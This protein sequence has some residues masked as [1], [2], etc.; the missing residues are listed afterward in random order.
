MMQSKKTN[1]E[2]EICGI[3]ALTGNPNVGKSTLF[4]GLTGM[5][6]HTGNWSGKTVS[7]ACGYYKTEDKKYMLIDLP[8][9]YSYSAGTAEE[10][11]TRD[12]LCFEE[13]DAV[14]VVCDA[15]CLERNM[16]LVLQTLEITDR[17]V[18]CIN[19]I[20]EAEK[21]GIETDAL[22]LEKL[23][24]ISVLR[25]EARSGKGLE[26]IPEIAVKKK[27]GETFKVNYGESA[28]KYIGQICG[29]LEKMGISKARRFCA[30]R[31]LCEDK[32]FIDSFEKKYGINPKADEE[33]KRILHKAKSEFCE[34]SFEDVTAEALVKTAERICGRIMRG[35]KSGYTRKERILDRI[36]TGRL[37][38]FCVM[39][40]FLSGIFWLTIEGANFISEIL[41]K[42][43][44]G[45]EAPFGELLRMLDVP[46]WIAKPLTEG[47]WRVLSWVVAVMLPPMAIFFPLFTLL[48]DFGYLPRIAFNLDR[49]F[50]KCNACGKQSLTMCMGFGCNAVGVTGCRIIDSPRERLIAMIT[51]SFVPCNG[52]FPALIAIITMFF[53]GVSKNTLS[54][55]TSAMILTLVIVVG[56][57][58]SFGAS[59]LLSGTLLRGMP[60]SFVLELPSY[61]RPQIWKVIV[62][63]VFDRTLFVLARAVKAAIPAGF[64]I[65]IMANVSIGNE[66]LLGICSQFLEPFGKMIGLDGIILMAF[67][68]SLPANEIMLPLIIMAYSSSKTLSEAESLASLY[69]LLKA[70]GWDWIRA[71][72]VMLF[73]LMHWPCATTL[74]TIKKESGS[75]KWTVVAFILPT[76]FGITACFLFNF[77]A[78]L[79]V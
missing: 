55:I 23:L 68:L 75:M 9:T 47:M 2:N 6:Q 21:K 69:T 39:L 58:A 36:F 65:W 5:H 8:G 67:I 22:A 3:I 53:A 46:L 79:F 24:G 72:C 78:R 63:S 77:I 35:N 76:L 64:V 44:S 34:E 20:D 66:T 27:A 26:K 10:G 52:R 19:L 59:K 45:L 1:Q 70:N 37:T 13:L 74:M 38:G 32:S 71:V 15:T 12:F 17:T 54:S 30:I 42:Y 48:E 62:R 33:I 43:L 14:V 31:L 73:S 51:N 49:V 29:C 57:F 50:K 4:N 7:N 18:V 25:T 56:I 60:S 61:R 11:V 16:N 28:E 40:L 41:S